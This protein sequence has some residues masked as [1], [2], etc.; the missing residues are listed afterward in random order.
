MI[1][2]GQCENR[3][4]CNQSAKRHLSAVPG[5]STSPCPSRLLCQFSQC[6]LIGMTSDSPSPTISS[7]ECP[8][9]QAVLGRLHAQA[10]REVA[11]TVR[12]NVSELPDRLLR[13]QVSAAK[14]AKRLKNLYQ[15]VN[16]KQGTFLY[17]V[18]RSVGARRIIEYGS[19]FGI[20]TMYLAA[21]VRDNG[22]GLV[23]GSELEPTK[24]LKARANISE[25]GLADLV[26]IREGD[27]SRTLQ[28]P[29]G[30]VDMAFLDGLKDLYLTIVEMLTP[31]LRKGAV[32]LACNI[33]RYKRSLAPYVAYMSDPSN[34]FSSATLYLLA[35][36]A[37]SVRL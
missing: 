2:R 25:A 28:D 20:S 12:V 35:G 23:I 1:R 24:V 37:Y 33:F 36:S 7:L 29:G 18:A 8:K 17:L 11:G 26:E 13:R 27:A 14:E 34:G 10:D 9:L 30:V 3:L 22:G 31:H 32:V 15:S 16:R 21:A 6:R 5:G 4:Y 19:S